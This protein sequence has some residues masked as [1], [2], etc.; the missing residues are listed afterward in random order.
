[1]CKIL[2]VVLLFINTLYA[3][4]S[5]APQNTDSIARVISEKDTLSKAYKNPR[6]FLKYDDSEITKVPLDQNSIE[7]YQAAEDF[8]YKEALPDDNWWTRLKQKLT[9]LYHSFIHWLLDGDEA[10]G[11]WAI[12]VKLLPYL[13]VA[14][15][16]ALIVWLFFK[17]DS[18]NLLMEKIKAPETFLSD[19]EALIQR[20]DLQQLLD[21][22]ISNENYRIAVRYYYLL[23]LQKMSSKDLIH[24]EVQKTNHDYINEI[25]NLTTQ[26][27]FS[28]VTALYDYIWYGNFEVDVTAFAK[29]ELAFKTLNNS[30]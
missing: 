22:A 9:D 8:N 14:G 18:G 12:L 28:K 7:A 23:V 24:W 16:V 26:T 30:I 1:M 15:V 10:V 25:K 6:Q 2:F 5:T 20:P 13:L 17:M 4:G 19:D 27:Q 29:A 21:T 11:I 3:K